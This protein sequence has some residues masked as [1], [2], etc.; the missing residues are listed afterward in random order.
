MRI[1]MVGTRGVP[2]RT[3]GAERVVGEL[4]RELT[5]LGDEVIVYGRAGY[6]RA[7]PPSPHARVILTPGLAGKHVDTI[8]HTATAMCDLLRRGVD[9]VHIHSPGPAILSWIPALAGKPI[10]FTVHAGDWRRAKWSLGARQMLEFGLWAGMH[11]ADAVTAVSEPLADELARRFHREVHLIPNAAPQMN[12]G[13]PE[14]LSR[15][16]LRPGQYVLYVGRAEPEKRLD[17]L[18]DAWIAGEFAF[19]LVVVGD[20]DASSYGR[21]CR[22]RAAG[23]NIRFL[24]SRY[25]QSL[26][27]L[28]AHALLL[29]QP[30]LLEGMSM[31]MLEAQALGCP[32]LA[33]DIEENRAAF[34]ESILYFFTE[35]P[36]ILAQRI[37]QCLAKAD[38]AAR[39][40]SSARRFE[41]SGRS[42]T[43]VARQLRVVYRSVSG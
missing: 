14:V 27:A 1:A 7:A 37:R 5:R 25:G 23:G 28:Y 24:G 4:S 12:P 16:G 19:P 40:R 11:A 18:I 43:D 6:L 33:A 13:P 3:G 2:A 22:R 31:V 32:I 9:V 21:S 30:S 39:Y 35:K 42:W 29:V 10:V 15:W 8:T 38:L 26:G 17:L 41:Q 20:V 34:G 36:G